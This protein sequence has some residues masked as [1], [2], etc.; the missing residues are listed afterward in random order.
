MTPDTRDKTSSKG[1]ALITGAS[2]ASA[3]SMQIDWR[4]VKG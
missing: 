3:P 2:P 4:L 1:I